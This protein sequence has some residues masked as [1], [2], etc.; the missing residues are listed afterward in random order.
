MPKVL[1]TKKLVSILATSTSMIDTKEEAL[2]L[3]Y[4][5]CI[6]ESGSIQ[7]E[8]TWDLGQALID[9]RNKVSNIILAYASKLSLKVYPINV[10]AQKIDGSILKIFEMVLAS[11]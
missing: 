9:S 10:R 2:V 3:E 11:F 4:V 1:E 5:L 6:Q 8:R 7:E